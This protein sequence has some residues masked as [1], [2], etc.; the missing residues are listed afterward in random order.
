M[1]F[2]VAGLPPHFLFTTCLWFA[3]VLTETVK[4][5]IKSLLL[6]CIAHFFSVQWQILKEP[7]PCVT[8]SSGT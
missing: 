1:D 6:L 4:Q 2:S 7:L 3:F 5:S 8:V